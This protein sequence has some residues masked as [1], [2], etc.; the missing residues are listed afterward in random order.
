MLQPILGFISIFGDNTAVRHVTVDA[1][2]HPPV[3]APLPARVGVRHHVAIDA[4]LRVIRQVRGG[5]GN[6][7]QNQ[8]HAQRRARE[9][10]DPDLQRPR[11]TG[12]PHYRHDSIDDLHPGNSSASRRPPQVQ[13]KTAA[14]SGSPNALLRVW[15]PACPTNPSCYVLP[16][17]VPVRHFRARKRGGHARTPLRIPR[18]VSPRRQS[19]NPR[20]LKSHALTPGW[21]LYRRNERG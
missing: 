17:E 21:L 5:I 8:G 20:T 4:G 1:G 10:I 11:Q 12:Q 15:V 13:R 9:T 19:G 2:R 3:T 14:G 7:D 18:K 6:A 16:G